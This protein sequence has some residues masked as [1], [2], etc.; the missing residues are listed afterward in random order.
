MDRKELIA[1]ETL[2]DPAA[3]A[4]AGQ[5]VDRTRFSDL[6]RRR[7]QLWFLAIA[8]IGTA[9]IAIAFALLGRERF[10]GLPFTDLPLHVVVALVG[11]LVPAVLLY[12]VHVEGNLRKLHELVLQERLRMQRLEEMDRSRRD[13]LA[14]VTHEIKTP[15]NSIIGAVQTLRRYGEGMRPEDQEHFIQIVDRNS[16]DLLDLVERVLAVEK[17]DHDGARS[18]IE[19]APGEG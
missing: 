7:I 9:A 2:A 5:S 18:E 10:P 19:A 14:T 8:V 4:A 11:G 15:L 3:R 17:I 13:F 16:R 12:V 6:D 1:E